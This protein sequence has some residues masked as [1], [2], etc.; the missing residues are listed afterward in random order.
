MT[1][2][3]RQRSDFGTLQAITAGEGPIVLLVHGVGL[4]AE[5]W[6]AQIDALAHRFRVIAV[7][8]PG[9]GKSPLAKQI[10]A[11]SDYTDTIAA[12][13]DATRLNPDF[14]GFLRSIDVGPPLAAPGT[15]APRRILPSG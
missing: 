3:T 11:L 6:A 5:A 1:W 8:M 9:H 2:T 10:T 14:N 4:Q 12:G 7:D 13:L 15:P